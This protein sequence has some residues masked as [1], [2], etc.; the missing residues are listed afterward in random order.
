MAQDVQLPLGHLRGRRYILINEWGPYNFEYPSVWLRDIKGEEYIFLLLGPTGN[1]KAVDGEGFLSIVPKTGTFPATVRAR[2]AADRQDLRLQFEFIGEA[3]VDQFGRENG[4]GDVYPFTFQRFEP[5]LEWTV[6]W[7]AYDERNAPIDHYDRFR[8]LTN[9]RPPARE[10]VT[11]LGYRWWGAPQPGVPADAFATFASATLE[12][13]PGQYR[14]TF[15]SDDGLR[16]YLD[17]D[18][19]IDHWTVHEA[20]V[21]T[22]TVELSGRHQ[23]EVEHFDAEGMATLDFYMEKLRPASSETAEK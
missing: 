7:Y 12:V 23:L 14:L 18:R 5:Q 6:R 1:W 3:F 10:T 15:T 22:A 19:I 16:V 4:R 2:R 13:E 17:G 20:T 8:D 11:D 21:D 9:R